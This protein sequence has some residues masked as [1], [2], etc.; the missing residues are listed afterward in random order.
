MWRNVVGNSQDV[1]TLAILFGLTIF[2]HELAH[3]LVARWCGMKVETFS[4]GFGPAIWKRKIRGTVYKLGWIPFG[5][6]VSLPQ[7]DP[8]AME[9]VQGKV[10]SKGEPVAAEPLPLIQPWKK[11]LVS[12]SGSMGNLIFALLLAWIIFASP[13]AGTGQQG[14]LRIN[15]VKDSPASIAGLRSG[16]Q[17]VAI[18][19]KKVASWYD[20]AVECLLGANAE[21]RVTVTVQRGAE[22]VPVTVPT[23]VAEGGEGRSIEGLERVESDCLFGLVVPGSPADRAGLKTGDK[24]RSFN[25]VAVE[26]WDRFVEMVQQ[27]APGVPAPIVVERNGKEVAVSVTPELNEKHGKIM[28][29]V[30]RGEYYGVHWMQYRDPWQQVKG[31]ISGVFRILKALGNRKEARQAAGALGGPVMIFVALWASIKIS[32]LN[33][34]GFLRLL[35]VNL[36]VI[37]LLPIPVLDGG[38]LVFALIETVTRRKMPVKVVNMLVNAFAAALIA[39][40]LLITWRDIGRLWNLREML[41]GKPAAVEAPAVPGAPVPAGSAA[42]EPG[43]KP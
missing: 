31:D 14:P 21:G 8:S 23:V 41:G 24:V 35:N 12:I 32:I 7:L 25:G 4:I 22:T 34:L 3:Y 33:A 26:Q 27:V 11:M 17:V 36:A 16:D 2:V 5:G 1:I 19:A 6:Y 37:N 20:F 28:I 13:N 38:L 42:A 30:Q 43:R 39:A 18:N 15:V 29:G 10:D 40:M 9:A